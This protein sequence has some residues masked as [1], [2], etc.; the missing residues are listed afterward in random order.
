[1]VKTDG[2]CL[3]RAANQ[4]KIDDQVEIVFNDGNVTANVTGVEERSL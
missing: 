4:L 1:M 3:V 2:D